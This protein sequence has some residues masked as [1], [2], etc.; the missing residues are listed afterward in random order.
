MLRVTLENGKGR[1]PV[2]SIIITKL[3]VLY[4]NCLRLQ[5]Q[6]LLSCNFVYIGKKHFPCYSDC[7]ILTERNTA[8]LVM[9][10]YPKSEKKVDSGVK[11]WAFPVRS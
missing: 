9:K 1:S 11:T 8:E 3:L 7:A 5:C 10:N 6:M 2:V 4:D